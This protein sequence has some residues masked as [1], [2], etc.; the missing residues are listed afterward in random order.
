M[1]SRALPLKIFSCILLI[2]AISTFCPA[3]NRERNTIS[4]KAGGVNSV[5]GHVTVTRSTQAPQLLTSQDDLVSGDVVNSGAG[6]QAEV[7]LNPGAYLRLAE[8][9]QFTLVDNSLDKLLVQL[10]SGNAIIEATGPDGI[11]LHIPVVTPQG[12]LTIV[13]RG[14]YRVNVREGVTEVLIRKGRVQLGDDPKNVAK[15]GSRITLTGGT[16][17]LAKL[18]KKDSDAFD[19]WSKER[20]ETL[21]RANQRLS[22][23]LVN[24]YLSSSLGSW[25]SSGFGS[26]GLWTFSPALR[27]FTFLP[28]YYGWT[29]PYGQFYGSY[30]PGALYPGYYPGINNRPVIT[31]NWPGSTPSGSSPSSGSIGVSNPARSPSGGMTTMPTTP[32]APASQA[33]P[34]DP[35]SGSR[36]INR[37]RDP[38]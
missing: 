19:Q 38:H 34:R 5:V 9:S 7:L 36:A 35:D 29:S 3:Q 13:R 2:T 20:G 27:C 16:S 8:N 24:G 22:A 11:D 14:I 30:I 31:N 21:A 17:E 26:W 25:P 23:R 1:T 4:A 18:D 28:F 37:V 15:N 10:D 12:R 33:G 6:G 32:S